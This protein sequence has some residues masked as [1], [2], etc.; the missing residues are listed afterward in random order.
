[1][2]KFFTYLLVGFLL[3]SAICLDASAAKKSG[4]I[5]KEAVQQMSD[6]IDNITKKYTLELYFHLKTMR[7]LSALRFN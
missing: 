4:K 1:M 2:K 6:D 5:S 3:I 7:L